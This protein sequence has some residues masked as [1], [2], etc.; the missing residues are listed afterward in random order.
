MRKQGLAVVLAARWLYLAGLLWQ[1]RKTRRGGG[2]F[3]LRAGGV[4]SGPAGLMGA[5][6]SCVPTAAK[7]CPQ[8]QFTFTIKSMVPVL[9]GGVTNTVP[10]T[11]TGIIAGDANGD[12]YR[13]VTLSGMGAWSSQGVAVKFIPRE[14]LIDDDGLHRERNQGNV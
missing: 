9:L 6:R 8:Y 13:E 12:T 5:Q 10:N 2:G 4:R 1:L 11:T 3:E 14:E 7:P